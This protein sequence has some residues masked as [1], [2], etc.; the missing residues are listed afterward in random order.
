MDNL[1]APW[2]ENIHIQGVNEIHDVYRSSFFSYA[3][4]HYTYSTVNSQAPQ[5][6]R[7]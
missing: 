5:V 2:V 1:T 4:S 6:T 7:T 3:P